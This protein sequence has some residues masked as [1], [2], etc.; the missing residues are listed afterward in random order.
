MHKKKTCKEYFGVQVLLSFA[1]FARLRVLLPLQLFSLSAMFP[2]VFLF[3]AASRVL[4]C[5]FWLFPPFCSSL[6]HVPSCKFCFAVRLLFWAE[7]GTPCIKKEDLQK[8]F[9]CAS[10]V[11][12]CQFCM[13]TGLNAPCNFCFLVQL[14]FW[15]EEG[16]TCTKKKTCREVF[17]VQV[18]LSLPVLHVYGSCCPLQ[19]LFHNATFVFL[20]KFCFFKPFS[21]STMFPIAGFVLFCVSRFEVQVL[22]LSAILLIL[23]S[24]SLVQL[25]FCRATF[26]LG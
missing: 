15:A 7:G 9:R 20:C 11:F 21:L 25:L 19:L 12:F 22:S 4:K 1:C 18:L 16:K 5:T 14:L 23:E 3:F 24:C 6:S 10:F 8:G 17:G 13:S 2:I 26:V